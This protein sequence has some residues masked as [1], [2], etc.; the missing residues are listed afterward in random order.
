MKTTTQTTTKTSTVRITEFD[1]KPTI[2]KEKKVSEHIIYSTEYNPEVY[3]NEYKEFCED[4]GYEMTED[5]LNEY[6]YQDNSDWLECEKC[7]LSKPMNTKF[8]IIADL[9]LWDG[10]RS[11]FRVMEI[12]N[13]NQIFDVYNSDS[14]T[15]FYCDRYDVKVRC[16][17]HDGTNYYTIREIKEGHDKAIE[18]ICNSLY[19]NEKVNKALIT[20]YTKSIRP[21]VANV[22]GW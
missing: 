1:I 12:K 21:L 3:R 16:T 14:E 15:T 6:A 2:K 9:G 10:R 17:H 4:N 7:N 13:L 5:G 11:G 20:K 22:F 19:F 8:L 18:N